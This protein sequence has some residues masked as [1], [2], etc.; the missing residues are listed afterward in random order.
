M[1]ILQSSHSRLVCV[2]C[3]TLSTDVSIFSMN[4]MGLYLFDDVGNL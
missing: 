2:S 3:K 4:L 1:I